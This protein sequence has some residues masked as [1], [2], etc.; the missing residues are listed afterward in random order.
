MTE[1]YKNCS[2]HIPYK[3]HMIRGQDT[4]AKAKANPSGLQGP[5]LFPELLSSSRS[6]LDDPIPAKN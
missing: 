4:E 6:V 2:N 1:V 3:L 5:V